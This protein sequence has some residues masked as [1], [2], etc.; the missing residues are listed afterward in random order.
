MKRMIFALVSLMG[1][2]AF[3]LSFNQSNRDY[4]IHCSDG[5]KS[6]SVQENAMVNSAHGLKICADSRPSMGVLSKPFSPKKIPSLP[7]NAMGVTK[8]GLK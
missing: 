6:W 1:S 4:V 5:G 7:R 8:Q 2:T 3:G